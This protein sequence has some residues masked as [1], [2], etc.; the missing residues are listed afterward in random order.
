MSQMMN[1]EEHL[2]A[3]TRLESHLDRPLKLLVAG[4]GAMLLAHELPMATADIDAFPFQSDWTIAEVDKIAKRVASELNIRA[5]WLNPYFSSFSYVI[6]KDY[7]KRLISVYKGKM[8]RVYALGA[9]DL[10]VLKCFAGREK[11]VSHARHLMKRCKKL[12]FVEK[13]LEL[14]LEKNIPKAQEALDFFDE[15]KELIGKK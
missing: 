2:K 11:D 1:K 4:G 13:H 8:L 10:L 5:D 3:L 9:E 6:P 12:R 14:M 15:I 7:A